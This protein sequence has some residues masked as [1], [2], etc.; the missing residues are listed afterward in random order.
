MKL[1]A[2]RPLARDFSELS[3]EQLRSIANAMARIGAAA[4]ERERS[5]PKPRTAALQQKEA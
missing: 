3:D 4:A 2:K 5:K 1:T